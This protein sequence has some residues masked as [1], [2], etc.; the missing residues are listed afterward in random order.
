GGGEAVPAGVDDGEVVVAGDVA[1]PGALGGFDGPP[2]DRGP[3]VCGQVRGSFGD[4]HDR[5]RAPDGALRALGV[6][7]VEQAVGLGV[8]TLDVALVGHWRG[9]HLDDLRGGV[10][11]G[12][13]VRLIPTTFIVYC[14]AIRSTAERTWT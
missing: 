6:Q 13:G 8:G 4:P 7:R 1:D 11:P 9:R 3:G 10:E 12:H 2:A 14:E 5:G